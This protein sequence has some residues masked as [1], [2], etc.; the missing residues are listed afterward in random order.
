MH[1]CN[2]SLPFD[3]ANELLIYFCNVYQME[4][5]KMHI[6]LTEL[7]SN[8]KNTARMFSEKEMVTWS[9]LKRGNRLQKFGFSDL[10]V[11]LGLTV[12]YVDDDRTLRN[13]ILLNSDMYEILREEVLKQSLLRTNCERLEAKRQ[14]IWLHMLRVDREFIQSE[15]DTYVQQQGENLQRQIADTID[16]DVVRSFNNLKEISQETLKKILKSYAYINKELNYC[17]GMNFIAGF[18]YLAMDKQEA[19]AFAVMREIIE[20]QTMTHLFNTELP[21][22]KLM[23]YQLDRLISINLPDLHNHFKVST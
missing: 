3:Q 17:Q 12:R 8:Q 16:V 23:F 1:F 14:E 6:L 19:L 18:L 11:I 5:S 4:K 21:M 15:F 2:M 9:L 20:R 13:L 10:S 7:M 22:L